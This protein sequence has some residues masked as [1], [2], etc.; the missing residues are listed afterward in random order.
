MGDKLIVQESA[1]SAGV[2]VAKL[3]PPSFFLGVGDQGKLWQLRRGRRER[4]AVAGA[5]QDAPCVSG[6]LDARVN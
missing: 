2:R 1:A 6:F 3:V 5:E 4:A